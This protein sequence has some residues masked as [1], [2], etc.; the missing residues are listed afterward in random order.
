MNFIG[1]NSVEKSD[2]AA[3]L[4]PEPLRLS[5]KTSVDELKE[6]DGGKYP[7]VSFFSKKNFKTPTLENKI[8]QE[9]F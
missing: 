6:I 4:S 1:S 7:N 3:A 2:W 9:T 8:F 5:E